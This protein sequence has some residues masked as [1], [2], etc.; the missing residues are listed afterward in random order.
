MCCCLTQLYNDRR[1]FFSGA[2]GVVPNDAFGSVA[3]SGPNGDRR[4]SRGRGMFLLSYCSFVS[5]YIHLEF[6]S[7]WYEVE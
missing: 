2:T 6:S 1:L 3:S 7:P 5:C 4:S